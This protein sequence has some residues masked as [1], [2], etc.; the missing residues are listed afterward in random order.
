ME[1]LQRECFTSSP[2]ARSRSLANQPALFGSWIRQRLKV[3]SY[4]RRGFC[5][6]P[7]NKYESAAL[8]IRGE[9]MASCNLAFPGYG[10]V[11]RLYRV[12]NLCQIA[13]VNPVSS[14][15]LIIPQIKV[16]SHWEGKTQRCAAPLN[17]IGLLHVRIGELVMLWSLW[18]I[19]IMNPYC[20]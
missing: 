6:A 17:N 1:L 2:E 19:A 12:W 10:K 7:L 16:Y 5:A 13:I 9:L 15:I 8:S 4:W 18:Q 3:F 11:W 20:L 14:V